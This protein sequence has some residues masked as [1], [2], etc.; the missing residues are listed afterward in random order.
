MDNAAFSVWVGKVLKVALC[1]ESLKCLRKGL[2]E[3]GRVSIFLSLISRHIVQ[4]GVESWLGRN[5]LGLTGE[6]ELEK[7]WHSSN[8]GQWQH[9]W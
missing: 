1:E 5:T 3:G 4:G 2:L 8:M 6:A 7:S 9:T